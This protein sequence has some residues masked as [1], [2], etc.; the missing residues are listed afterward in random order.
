LSSELPDCNIIITN[1]FRC[2]D[3]IKYIRYNCAML[4]NNSSVRMDNNLKTLPEKT[5]DSFVS[6]I[7]TILICLSQGINS[8]TEISKSTG[9][10]KSTVHRILQTLEEPG[11]ITYDS[12]NHQYYLGPLITHLSSQVRSSH[13]YLVTCALEEMKR[14][15]ELTRET[16]SLKILVGLESILL[17]VIESAH[18]LNVRENNALNIG[19][20]T[21]LTPFGA[22]E[23]IL[24]SQLNDQELKASLTSIMAGEIKKQN[25]D[26][27]LLI[28]QFNQFRQQ[29][30]SIS[31]GERI[32]GAL[33][34][35]VPV[36][37]YLCPVSLGIIGPESRL[38]LNASALLEELKTSGSR[39]SESITS[40]SIFLK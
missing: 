28:Q 35:A 16:V 21:K 10:N 4:M 8:V 25:L 1:N 7:S 23:N 19:R 27:E 3:K 14:L 2:I 31:H 26:I 39:V 32:P 9:F 37:N 12:L 5:P 33:C 38:I 24:L 34:I 6:R 20:R 18:G 22:W 17:Y 11:F 29:G 40:I 36:K 30:Y 15:H 13:Q